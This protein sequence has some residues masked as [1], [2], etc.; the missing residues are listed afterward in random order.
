M[1][2][3][4]FDFGC[5]SGC[6]DGRSLQDSGTQMSGSTNA[7]FT[8]SHMSAR[9]LCAKQHKLLILAQRSWIPAQQAAQ[10]VQSR[11]IAAN[12]VAE[13]INSHQQAAPSGRDTQ[14]RRASL[15]HREDF[16]LQVC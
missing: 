4:N 2:S 14:V 10:H 11:H 15:L 13:R 7:A 1:A 12:A 9:L 16:V 6:G 3:C 8:P 5:D